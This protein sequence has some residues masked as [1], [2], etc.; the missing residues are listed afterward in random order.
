[1]H[2]AASRDTVARMARTQKKRGRLTQDQ[3]V[4]AVLIAAMDANQHVSREEAWR[5]HHLIWSMR[6]F[7]RQPGEKVDRLIGIVRDRMQRFG[8]SAVLEDAALTLEARLR[9]P[10]FAV[11]IDLMLADA[12]LERSERAFIKRLAAALD[13]RPRDADA[14]VRA[15]LIKNGV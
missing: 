12:A 9:L 6:R 5:A 13:I 11:A 10:V 7:R 15:M 1:M 3:A 14:I 8:P 4:I 2:G